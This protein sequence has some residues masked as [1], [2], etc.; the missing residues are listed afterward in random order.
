METLY[1]YHPTRGVIACESGEIRFDTL[2][3]ARF[4][5]SRLSGQSCCRVQSAEASS[6]ERTGSR[7]SRPL[8]IENAKRKAGRNFNPDDWTLEKVTDFRLALGLYEQTQIRYHPGYLDDGFQNP[9]QC[10]LVAKATESFYSHKR[11]AINSEFWPCYL[12]RAE[13][14]RVW[15][16]SDF[17]LLAKPRSEVLPCSYLNR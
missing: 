16:V 8:C 14:L 13:E 4:P 9:W 11:R 12:Q 3:T 15:S 17:L 6:Q 2:A 1:D 5:H 10:L 7:V